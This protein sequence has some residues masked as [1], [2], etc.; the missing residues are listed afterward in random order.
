MGRTRRKRGGA[1]SQDVSV[2]EEAI[3]KV[4]KDANNIGTVT[5]D[6]FKGKTP[7]ETAQ[8]KSG[9]LKDKIKEYK[10]SIECYVKHPETK[11]MVDAVKDLIKTEGER[12]IG[13][14]EY[15]EMKEED[16]PYLMITKYI[17]DNPTA[18]GRRRRKRRRRTKKRKS[19]RR[20][21]R[22]KKKRRRR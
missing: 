21:K 13:I 11:E 8:V 17:M 15:V 16:L 3:K 6:A 22:T 9:F 1:C 14:E 20:R 4:T 7:H 12:T 2:T 18:G 5:L 19:R 10:N